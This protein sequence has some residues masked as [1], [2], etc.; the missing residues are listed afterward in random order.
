M[1]VLIAIE[2]RSYREV[3][4][5]AIEELRPNLRVE[6]VEPGT[7]QSEVSRLRP[8]LVLCGGS[9]TV[10]RSAGTGAKAWFEFQPYAET[11]ATVCLGGEI[12]KIEDV[13]LDDILSVIDAVERLQ[14]SRA[15]RRVIA[16]R[17]KRCSTLL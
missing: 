1:K 7:L 10:S 6:V 4:G 15:P 17:R 11:Q 5:L 9:D 3:I 12:S 16:A 2:P 13:D 8:D 14:T